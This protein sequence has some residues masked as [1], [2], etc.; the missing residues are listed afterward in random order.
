ME[1]LDEAAVALTLFFDLKKALDTEGVEYTPPLMGIPLARFYLAHTLFEKQKLVEA[2]EVGLAYL[3]DVVEAGPQAIINMPN[4]M[5]GRIVS[6]AERAASRF[7]TR[8]SSKE[9]QADAY[10]M[11]AIVAERLEGP[12]ATVPH[13]E[14]TI[15]L[16][17]D[18]QQAEAHD[19]LARTYHALQDS[20]KHA[21]HV[22]LS[23]VVRERIA[24]AEEA[25]RRKKEEEAAKERE[26]G[27]P[28]DESGGVAAALAGGGDERVPDVSEAGGS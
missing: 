27:A 5:L 21:E 17:N 11:L 2:K 20:A 9:A 22:E 10:T 28:D 23:K 16:G 26:E 19:N 13:F 24:A 7:K 15:E 8:A 6:D 25:A 14:K 12:A 4:G 18:K 1:Q 3:E